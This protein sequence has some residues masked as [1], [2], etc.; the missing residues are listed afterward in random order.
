MSGEVF[1]IKMWRVAL[2]VVLSFEGGLHACTRDGDVAS[3]AY[4]LFFEGAEKDTLPP[5]LPLGLRLV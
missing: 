2:G 5:L 4:L 3:L 1:D